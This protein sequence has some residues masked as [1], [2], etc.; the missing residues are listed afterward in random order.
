[1]TDKKKGK[2]KT[3]NG[4][5]PLLDRPQDVRADSDKPKGGVPRTTKFVNGTGLANREDGRPRSSDGK[6]LEKKDHKEPYRV[7]SGGDKSRGRKY[8]STKE[9][10]PRDR[11]N[12]VVKGVHYVHKETGQNIKRPACPHCDEYMTA[13]SY[14]PVG[15]VR[16]RCTP[17]GL[18]TTNPDAHRGLGY[19][20]KVAKARAQEIRAK[21]KAPST[22]PRAYV[23]TAAQ[24]NTPI[25]REFL[26]SLETYCE[27]NGAELIV[28]PIH[29]KN[30][31]LFTANQEYNKFW[32]PE[33]TKY[34]VD[35]NLILNQR[36]QIMGAHK[37]QATA[38]EPLSGVQEIGGSRW[39][40]YGH[41]QLSYIPVA[42]PSDDLPKR[43]YTT[44]V[45]TVPNYSR[46]KFG[47]K[48]EFHHIQGALVIELDKGLPFIRELRADESGGF[49]DLD[50]YYL[51]KEVRNSDEPIMSLVTGD[52][53]VKFHD[54]QVRKATY[55]GQYSIVKVLK[56]QYI[57]RHDILDTYFASHHHEKDPLLQYQKF[58][59]DSADDCGRTELEQVV[60]FIDSTTPDGTK[61]IIVASNHHEHLD[62]WLNRANALKDHRNAD[63]ILELQAAQRTAIKEQQD[64]RAL[65]LYLRPRVKSDCRFLTRNE[66]FMLFDTD[67]AQHGDKGINGS[68]GSFRA[69]SRTMHK[70]VIAHSHGAVVY[71]GIHQVGTSTGRLGYEQGL[72]T[73]TNTHCIQYPNG[74]KTNIDCFKGQWCGS[75]HFKD[76]KKRVNKDKNKDQ[77]K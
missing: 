14:T 70:M 52:E 54:R 58:H 22:R 21:I 6:L 60:K 67:F 39:C 27:H 31:S 13:A 68:R 20:A 77:K 23:V 66:K 65:P 41:S 1:M 28:I 33:V 17:C 2:N 40:I 10:P 16:W 75:W 36:V 38:A 49:Y 12:A 25:Y 64:Y 69:F 30:V 8:P 56:P 63:L 15:T 43:V 73:H 34:L 46:S 50:K 55:D 48:A 62:Q 19:D 61:N 57:I 44:G 53:H 29:Y 37:I 18:T 42:S 74:R 11:P 76:R 4:G 7:N 72:S 26:T 5:A 9:I 51:G 45:C 32:V 3:K 24:N 47:F 59:S 71:K 35:E